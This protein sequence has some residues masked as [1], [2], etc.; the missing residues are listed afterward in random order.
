MAR[1]DHD[2]RRRLFRRMEWVFVVAPPILAI[3][4]AGFGAA[5]IAWLIAIPGTTF[6][7]RWMVLV[8]IILGIPLLWLGIRSVL[9]NR[10]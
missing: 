6:W 2:E 3:F 8:A 1:G 5:F 4:V 7:G 10:R 9:E